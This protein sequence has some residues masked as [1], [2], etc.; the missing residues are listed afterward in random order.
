MAIIKKC[1]ICGKPFKGAGEIGPTCEEHQG[2]I[3]KYYVIMPGSPEQDAYISLVELCD[4]AEELGKSRYWMVKLTGGDGGV[5]P[6]QFPEFTIY[7]FS[8]KKYC[9]RTAIPTARELAGKR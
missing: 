3:G 2:L 4:L 8:G 5:K 1:K 7:Q 6:P 9:R